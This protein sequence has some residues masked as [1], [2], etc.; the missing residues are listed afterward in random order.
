MSKSIKSSGKPSLKNAM[1]GIRGVQSSIH[2]VLDR[3][4]PLSTMIGMA[5][6]TFYGTATEDVNI[7]ITECEKARRYNDW[8]GSEAVERLA[9]FLEGNARYAFEAEVADRAARLR[10]TSAPEGDDVLKA[11]RTPKTVGDDAGQSAAAPTGGSGPIPSVGHPKEESLADDAGTGPGPTEPRTPEVLAW[12]KVLAGTQGRISNVST[13]LASCD[14]SLQSYAT[15]KAE[16]DRAMQVLEANVHAPSSDGSEDEGDRQAQEDAAQLQRH[17]LAVQLA[18][19]RTKTAEAQAEYITL[20]QQR[21]SLRVAE[22]EQ[23]G[24]LESARARV[25]ASLA[26]EAAEQS[27]AKAE[28]SVVVVVD[29][30]NDTALAF[31]KFA[32]FC[33]WL[34]EVFE[35]E[36][37]TNSFMSEYYGRRQERG[38]K[39]QDFA[40]EVLRLS[41]RSGMQVSE[42]ERCKHFL[43]G[44]TPRMKK[45]IKRE[46]ERKGVKA[47][48]KYNWNT[49]LQRARKLE[50]DVP[51]LSAVEGDSDDGTEERGGTRRP[52]R[53][54]RR[55]MVASGIAEEEEEYQSEELDVDSMVLSIKEGALAATQQ[56][57]SE[58]MSAVKDM[59]NQCMTTQAATANGCS[60]C[61]SLNHA[62]GGCPTRAAATRRCYNCQEEGHLSRACPRRVAAQTS[63]TYG[64]SPRG[65]PRHIGNVQCYACK[66]MGHYS[67]A[68]PKRKPTGVHELTCYNC[69]KVGHT[70]RV[71][72][73]PKRSVGGRRQGNAQRA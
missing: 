2:D 41:M 27:S 58:L 55:H 4:R 17:Q 3:T 68:C 48:D 16:C 49:L 11:G 46:W 8:Q 31:P 18:D 65:A 69:N 19:I 59:V 23:A 20:L 61:G 12:A 62:L 7:F 39:V 1:A 56:G 47:K 25:K 26:K 28:S 42:V 5:P 15:E 34:R 51:E 72:P 57:M 30:E 53:Q 36:D 64:A 66:E 54:G 9:Y 40:Y 13:A 22:V 45:H 71:C 50:R 21:E 52:G 38:E 29:D 44:L 33:A 14:I 43:D 32:E 63:R 73:E 70:S 35:R 67:N 24:H 10:A 6:I 37:V 60:A